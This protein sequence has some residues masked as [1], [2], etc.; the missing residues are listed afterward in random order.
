M[1]GWKTLI[2]LGL[3]AALA[4]CSFGGER[5]VRPLND[6]RNRTGEPEEFSIVPNKPLAPPPSFSELPPPTPGQGNRTDATPKADLV[7]ALGGNPSQLQASG[8]AG[9][10]G[11]GDQALVAA[12]ARNGADPEIRRTLAAEDED[13]RK[14]KGRFSWSI[15]PD[16][17]YDR[18]YRRQKLD[19]WAWLRRYRNAGA[20]TPAAPPGGG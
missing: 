7:A 9:T 20:N 1:T 5:D 2:A 16:N 3:F 12:V 10:V 11:A 17:D 18:A 8:E 4:G 15:V 6:L 13:Y 19:P 14:R